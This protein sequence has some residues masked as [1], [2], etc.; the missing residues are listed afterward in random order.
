MLISTSY[1]ISAVS[2]LLYAWPSALCE[3]S[4][5]LK[6]TVQFS[7]KKNYGVECARFVCLMSVHFVKT[8]LNQYQDT[9]IS[10]K[11]LLNC[12]MTGYLFR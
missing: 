3:K 8:V 5:T 10:I 1:L 12:F 2:Y 9:V 11:I 7:I 6:H 4:A